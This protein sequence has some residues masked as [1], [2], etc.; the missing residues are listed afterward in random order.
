[1]NP[2]KEPQANT[3]SASQ[4]KKENPARKVMEK[5]KSKEESLKK[6]LEVSKE[7]GIK[8][9][10]KAPPPFKFENKMEK[11]KISIP[12]NEVIKKGE[13]RDQIIK[14]LNMEEAPNTLNI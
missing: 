13:Y 14:M 4:P 11:I 8:E 12:C 2:T 7:T 1:M 6:V 5:G 9:V 3:P 10:Y